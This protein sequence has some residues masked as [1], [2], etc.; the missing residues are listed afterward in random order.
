MRGWSQ[1][2]GFPDG[3]RDLT[4]LLRQ[5]KRM[6][7]AYLA[8]ATP[9]GFHS[10]DELLALFWPELPNH[11]ARHALSQSLHML[12]RVLGEEVIVTR[13]EAEIALNTAIVESDVER[14]AIQ[15]AVGSGGMATVYLAEDLKHHRRVAV[16]V[17]K[18]ELAAALGPQRFLREIETVPKLN[19][20]H[21]LPLFDSGEADGLLYYVMPY[22][23]GTTLPAAVANALSNAIDNQQSICT[24]HSLTPA[25]TRSSGRLASRAARVRTRPPPLR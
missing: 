5:P 24:L 8:A 13:G 3:G 17:L 18:P 16:K 25:G 9:R 1:A 10:R 20:P 14:Y 4:A 6:A 12:R 19:H 15:R 22:V 2:S 21:I 11:R 7:L 23:E